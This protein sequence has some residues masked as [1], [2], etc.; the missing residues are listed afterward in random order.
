MSENSPF[1]T[2]RD[3][4]EL[5]DL[6]AAQAGYLLR[7]MTENKVV[8]RASSGKPSRYVKYQPQLDLPPFSQEEKVLELAT[9]KKQITNE[10]IKSLLGTTAASVNVL[11]SGMTRKGLLIRVSR[12]NYKPASMQQA[13][14]DA[15]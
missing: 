5:L 11:L 7:K 4:M 1:F 6:S 10:E 3:V 8:V 14:N 9:G 2:K 12:G 15:E 13:S